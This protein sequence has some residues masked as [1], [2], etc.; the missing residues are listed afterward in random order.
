MKKKDEITNM[1]NAV[2]CEIRELEQYKGDCI[3]EMEKC[4]LDEL[5]IS[6]GIRVGFS[7]DGISPNTLKPCRMRFMRLVN[8][9]KAYQYEAYCMPLKKNGELYIE[10]NGGNCGHKGFNIPLE[11]INKWSLQ[12]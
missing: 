11:S 12:K 7:V 2:D 10:W 9:S 6:C 4:I 8:I 1:I 5:F 3:K